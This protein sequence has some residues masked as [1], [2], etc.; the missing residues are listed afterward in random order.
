MKIDVQKNHL[1]GQ[2]WYTLDPV[3]KQR[4]YLFLKNIIPIF[5][6]T[7]INTQNR[8]EKWYH[9]AWKSQL[10]LAQK[11]KHFFSGIIFSLHKVNF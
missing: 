7:V 10:N 3:K 1:G 9:S 8:I 2:I 5:S 6:T 11:K 4:L